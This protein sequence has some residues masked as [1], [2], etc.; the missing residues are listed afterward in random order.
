MCL[1]S[2]PLACNSG[3]CLK[4]LTL[5][6]PQSMIFIISR[7]LED[8]IAFRQTMASSQ[9]FTPLCCRPQPFGVPGP[10]GVRLICFV[11][12]I[13][14]WGSASLHEHPSTGFQA[15]L[16]PFW[17]SGCL[18]FSFFVAGPCLGIFI[19]V[20]WQKLWWVALCHFVPRLLYSNG[21]NSLFF[22]KH[23]LWTHGQFSNEFNCKCVNLGH[24]GF[25][26]V[27][28]IETCQ[29]PVLYS[30]CRISLCSRQD[31]S[32]GWFEMDMW[33]SPQLSSH[34]PGLVHCVHVWLHS[35]LPYHDHRGSCLQCKQNAAWVVFF[36]EG[37]KEEVTW[38]NDSWVR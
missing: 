18:S 30:Q 22:P 10:E 34:M 31:F 16:N 29:E 19:I 20:L 1:Q 27:L 35:C 17:N 4:Y 8:D 9:I 12:H 7:W 14:V 3:P 5:W 25:V 26:E 11:Q 33:T 28:S 2:L 24:R 38:G 36:V 37:M 23:L 15:V 6:Y 13:G 32:V 21:F